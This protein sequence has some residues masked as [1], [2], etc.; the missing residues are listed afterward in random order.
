MSAWSAFYP[1]VLPHVR[2][3]PDPLVDRALCDAAR[4]FCA[5][6]RAWQV[7]ADPV[8]S[9]GSTRTLEF[10]FPTGAELVRVERATVAGED[11]AILNADGQPADAD[12][13][14]PEESL[15]DTVVVIDKTQYQ[16]WPVPGSGD[17]IVILMALQPTVAAEGV[18]NVIYE[19]WGEGMAQGA[20]M[21]LKAMPKADWSDAD[22][23]A[24]AS[25]AF[26][27]AVHRAANWKFRQNRLL[28]TTLTPL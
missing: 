18:G 14:S 3:C 10:V 28:R 13:A 24:L 2:G 19:Q 8:A 15:A 4:E 27:R 25:G 9:D 26:E 5:R 11:W 7:K 17:E 21:R 12:E 23:A 1:W 6:S 20:L 16:L 22:G